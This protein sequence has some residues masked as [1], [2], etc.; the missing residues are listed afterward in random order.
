MRLHDRRLKEAK[1]EGI[2]VKF[3]NSVARQFLLLGFCFDF[4][5]LTIKLSVVYLRLD[6]I[7]LGVS[8]MI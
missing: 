6:G 5:R 7:S 2:L 1:I 8:I 3:K 4:L